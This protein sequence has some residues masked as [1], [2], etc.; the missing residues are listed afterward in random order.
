[1]AGV[2][3]VL[4]FAGRVA[5]AQQGKPLAVGDEAPDFTLTAATVDGVQAQP[6]RLGDFHDQT[7]IIAFF[8][9]ARSS[10]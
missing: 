8:Y 9:R 4:L 3:A 2:T 5:L 7:V 1:M 6:V 10:G